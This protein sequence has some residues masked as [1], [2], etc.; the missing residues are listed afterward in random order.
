LKSEKIATG[1]RGSRVCPNNAKQGFA[2]TPAIWA[3][4]SSSRIFGF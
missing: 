2:R 1:M 3:A 4:L